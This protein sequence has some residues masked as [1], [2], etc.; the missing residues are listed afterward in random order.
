MRSTVGGSESYVSGYDEV[1]TIS[2]D[3]VSQ[4]SYEQRSI[5]NCKQRQ[6]CVTSRCLSS[7]FVG[8]HSRYKRDRSRPRTSQLAEFA[9]KVF[10][11][12]QVLRDDMSSTNSS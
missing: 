4:R 3:T 8:A 11:P 2:K 1:P 7:P 10:L 5:K 12:L 9:Q 6:P